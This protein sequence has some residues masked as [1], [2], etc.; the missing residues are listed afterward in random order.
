MVIDIIFGIMESIIII[1]SRICI[2]NTLS[3]FS[4]LMVRMNTHPHLI[5]SSLHI[6]NRYSL[7][8]LNMAFMPEEQGINVK[9]WGN[10]SKIGELKKSVFR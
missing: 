4:R 10:K 8:K 6:R 1:V 9:I 5:N 3:S 2:G 7:R